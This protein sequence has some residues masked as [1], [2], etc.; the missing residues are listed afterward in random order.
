MR[1]RER[2]RTP[3]RSGGVRRGVGIIAWS[4]VACLLLPSVSTAAALAGGSTRDEEGFDMRETI[5]ALREAN[6]AAD[7]EA[8]ARLL[9]ELRAAAEDPQQPERF[10]AH[11]QAGTAS[12]LLASFVGPGSLAN[13]QGDVP[14][15]LRHMREAAD[16][17]EACIALAPG[18]ADAHIALAGN[19]GMRSGVE[20]ERAAELLGKS[21][22]ARARALSLGARNPRVVAGEAGYLFWAPPEAGG[23]RDRA[24][25]RYREAL[26]LFAAEPAEESALHAWGEADVWAFL[27]MAHFALDPPDAGAAKAAVE[28]ALALRPDFAWARG[29]LLPRVERALRAAP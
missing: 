2:T 5:A 7:G 26:A 13:P 17:F 25:A 22:A 23:N 27:A 15:M 3:V 24:L 28:R 4:A 20:P 9:G 18:Y 11:F 8:V 6:Y 1:E 12:T 16:S 19:Y 29:Y 10:R 14:L 21:S